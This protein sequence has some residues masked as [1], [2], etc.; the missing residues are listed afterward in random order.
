MGKYAV[1]MGLRD[2][3]LGP[4]VSNAGMA[5]VVLSNAG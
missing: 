3:D 1:E 4:V 2:I 5:A